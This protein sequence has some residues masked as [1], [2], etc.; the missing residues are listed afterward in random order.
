[1]VLLISF[2]LLAALVGLTLR[3]REELTWPEKFL[4]DGFG[5]VQGIVYAPVQHVADFFEDMKNIKELYE[6]NARLKAN[7]NEYSSMR[8]QIQELERQK[9]EL[10][11][12]LKLK[13]QSGI[14]VLT[15]A[16]VVGR[17]PSTWN[18]EITI[19]RGSKDG[20]EKDMAVVTASNGLVGR[21]FEVTAYHS[22]VLLIT[23][24]EKMGVS[25]KVLSEEN[26]DP[27]FGII[28]GAVGEV[29][30]PGSTSYVE[31]T[32]IPLSAKVK[33]GDSV[34]TSGLS[35]IFP[36]SLV[37]GTVIGVEEDKLHLTKTA[38]I[39][40]AANLNNLE[41]LYVVSKVQEGGQ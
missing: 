2:I 10:T 21:V 35:T 14:Q 16:N 1:M 24:K 9:R 3:E 6:E 39:K 38:K 30:K 33:E 25:A 17:S 15:G 28:G 11:K 41:F 7:L 27:V 23:D 5:W 18:A 12:D 40:P 4:I 13:D 8:V 22:K 31:I 37:I 34:V 32:G 20:V 19:D 26:G 29:S 36:K